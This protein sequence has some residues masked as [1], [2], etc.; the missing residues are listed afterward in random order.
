MKSICREGPKI[1]IRI[2]TALKAVCVGTQGIFVF[3]GKKEGKCHLEIHCGVV[4][5]KISVAQNC[6]QV[7][8]GPNNM[9]LTPALRLSCT[10]WGWPSVGLGRL[11]ALRCE[12]RG[13]PKTCSPTVCG[14]TWYNCSLLLVLLCPT[15]PF[16]S[17]KI[18]V[19]LNC[20]DWGISPSPGDWRSAR[21]D[22]SLQAPEE[23]RL[24]R[25]ACSTNV[26]WLCCTLEKVNLRGFWATVT[27]TGLLSML[28]KAEPAYNYITVL[29]LVVDSVRALLKADR[30]TV[31]LTG[32][33][34]LGRLL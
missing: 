8:E 14:H 1:V 18:W 25:A 22:P 33:E 28:R 10:H 12:V 16:P 29:F 17:L 20:G 2:S 34:C 6:L 21:S 7:S 26:I 5:Q 9:L 23:H 30:M 4:V 31:A 11:W 19:S 15:M 32:R 24:L 13:S 3:W 27:S